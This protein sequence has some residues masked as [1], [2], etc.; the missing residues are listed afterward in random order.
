MSI[1]PKQTTGLQADPVF[2]SVRPADAARAGASR[3]RPADAARSAGSPRDAGA[4]G[5]S[6]WRRGLRLMDRSDAFE[7]TADA[8]DL[9]SFARSTQLMEEDRRRLRAKVVACAIVLAVLLAGSLCLMVSVQRV[10]PPSEVLGCVG[11]WFQVNFGALFTTEVPLNTLQIMQLQPHYFEVTARF[12]ISVLTALCGAMLA[13]A[14]ALYQYVFKNP[15]A[16]P[17][18]LGVQSGVNVGLVILVLTMGTGALAATGAR[19]LLCYGCAA[20]ILLTVL[21]AGRLVGG[22]GAFNVVNMLLVGSIVSQ[23]AGTAVTYATNLWMDDTLYQVY[24]EVQEQLRADAS[25]ASWLALLAAFAVSLVPILATRFSMNAL[26][27][28]DEDARLCGVSPSALR[29]VALLS[30]SIMVTAATVYCGTVSMA[31]LLVPHIARA[32]FG[33]EFRKQLAG[34]MLLGAI[35]LLLCRDIVAVI[36]FLDTGIPIGTAVTFVTMPFFVWMLAMQ[37][38]SWE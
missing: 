23:L 12:S 28:A 18:M 25:A 34:S 2:G 8:A 36:P 7:L 19:Y 3:T 13:L 1:G 29:L 4:A 37:Q 17:T 38:R 9:V 33:A 10:M 32:L 11:L 16:A 20:A 6:S 31:S 5:E 21:L 26:S 27:L 14:G 35:L 22:T 15:I 24:F 30:G